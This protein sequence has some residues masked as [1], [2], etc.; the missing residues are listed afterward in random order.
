VVAGDNLF[1]YAESGIYRL[2]LGTLA[3]DLT[4]PLPRGLVRNGDIIPLPDGG[5]LLVHP[6]S[7]RRLIAF[8]PT[9]ALRWERSLAGITR[10]EQELLLIDGR[11]YLL[12]RDITTQAENA[13]PIAYE[14]TL[15]AID[16]DTAELTRLF[17]GGTRAP[18]VA[19][20]D[21]VP[22][23]NGRLAIN[24]AG[25]SIVLLDINQALTGSTP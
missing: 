23:G 18:R 6:D 1:L 24:I 20:T 25:A 12:A 8:D 14:L 15:F 22:L 4:Y 11:P 2:D 17:L 19:F 3:A 10:G 5:L 7:G 21:V 13:S 16:P 9:G